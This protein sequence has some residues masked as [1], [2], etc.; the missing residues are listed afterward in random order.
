[1]TRLN[2]WEDGELAVGVRRYPGPRDVRHDTKH[3]VQP[4]PV[5]G[6]EIA[7]HRLGAYARRGHLSFGIVSIGVVDVPRDLA[8]NADRLDFLEEP[9]S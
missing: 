3:E 2:A 8:V 1:M 4:D 6:L 9:V 5:T 7:V